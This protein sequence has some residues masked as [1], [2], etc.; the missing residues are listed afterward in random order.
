M[1]D[2]TVNTDK[3]EANEANEAEA[4]EAD[5]ADVDDESKNPQCQ[6]EVEVAETAADPTIRQS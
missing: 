2:K 1:T 3:A 5:K 6:D 4:D